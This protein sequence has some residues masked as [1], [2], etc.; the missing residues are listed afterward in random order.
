[1]NGSLPKQDL[2]KLIHALI[3]NRL[4]HRHGIFAGLKKKI[5]EAD[6]ADFWHCS[7]YHTPSVMFIYVL[8]HIVLLLFLFIFMLLQF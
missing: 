6:A 7:L 8:F 3:F 2:G 5:N 4:Y 1:M